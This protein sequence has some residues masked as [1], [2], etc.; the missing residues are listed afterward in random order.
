MKFT[1]DNWTF[2]W[3]EAGVGPT[4]IF[5]SRSPLAEEGMALS[6]ALEQDFFVICLTTNGKDAT[7]F[8]KAVEAFFTEQQLW[9]THWVIARDAEDL[10]ESLLRDLPRAIW[11]IS[12]EGARLKDPKVKTIAHL[13][14]DVEAALRQE[15]ARV[16][17]PYRTSE[18]PI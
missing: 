18:H 10:A 7:K 9:R 15:F 1:H 3:S 12:M 14:P 2:E 5:L 16:D 11:S 13:A 8:A 6:K 17:P 4:V